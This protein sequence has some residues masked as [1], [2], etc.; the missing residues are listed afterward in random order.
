[1]VQPTIDRRQPI[2]DIND[3]MSPCLPSWNKTHR[4]T[5][6]KPL[7]TANWRYQS[8][9]E[10]SLSFVKFSYIEILK[11]YSNVRTDENSEVCKMIA[12]AVNTSSSVIYCCT[13]FWRPFTTV[14]I[15]VFPKRTYWLKILHS[16][17][18]IMMGKLIN[19][20]QFNL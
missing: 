10:F 6:M 12:F 18:Q 1:M 8:K 5:L 3:N 7:K 19:F 13:S 17:L 14:G 11:T 4:K 20:G 2:V 9:V 15:V 16:R